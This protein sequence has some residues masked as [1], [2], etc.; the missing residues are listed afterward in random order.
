M[1]VYNILCNF[2]VIIFCLIQ[3]VVLKYFIVEFEKVKVIKV[4]I[5]VDE[6]L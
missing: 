3:D 6:L 2:E 1:N 4:E 5:D